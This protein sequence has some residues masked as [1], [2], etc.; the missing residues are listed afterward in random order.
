[1]AKRNQEQTAAEQP[2]EAELSEGAEFGEDS[3]E[4]GGLTVNLSDVNEDGNFVCLP[5]GVYPCV[6]EELNFEYSQAKNNP[7]WTWIWAIEDNHE[8]KGRKFF[9]HTTFNEGGLPRVKKALARIQD[10]SGYAKQLLGTNFSPEKVALEGKLL[11]A[12][13]GV[14][15]NIKKYEGKDRNNVVDILPPSASGGAD[16]FLSS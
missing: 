14:K 15:V 12:R 3:G 1:M 16:S 10:D 11:G 5:R 7:M 4:G 6:L 13:A 8:H 9:Y 2:Q